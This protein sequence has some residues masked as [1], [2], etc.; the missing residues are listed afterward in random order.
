MLAGQLAT[1]R[2]R[3]ANLVGGLDEV[4]NGTLHG[5]MARRK[6]FGEVRQVAIGC[7]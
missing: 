6:S 7:Q 1:E 4:L 3:N 5:G 2:T